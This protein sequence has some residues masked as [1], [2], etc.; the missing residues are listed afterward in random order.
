MPQL[1]LG[2]GRI[3]ELFVK[4]RLV[5]SVINRRTPAV[6]SDEIAHPKAEE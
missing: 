1:H 4:A 2:C 6:G 5:R 3:P